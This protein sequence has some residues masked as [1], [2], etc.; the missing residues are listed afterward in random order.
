M[1]LAP[2]ARPQC[3]GWFVCALASRSA[4]DTLTGSAGFGS[5]EVRNQVAGHLDSRTYR[6]NYQD[7]CIALD[8]ASLVRGQETEDALIR[9]LNDVG[10][11]ADPGANVALSPEALEYIASLPDVAALQAERNRLAQALQEKYGSISRA[12][13]CE[14]LLGAYVQ[15]KTAHRTRKEFHKT[16]MRSQ[17]RQDFFVHKNAALIEAQ[18]LGG[19]AKSVNRPESKESALSIPERA[20]L[21]SLIGVGDMRE[22]SM[23]AQRAAAVEA[24]ADLCSRAELKRRPARLYQAP[25]D[26]STP[27][28]PP[29][30]ADE[31]FPMQCHHLQC[32]FC[33]GDTVL[34]LRDRTQIFSQQHTLW[35]HVA[36]H[37]D[38][39]EAGSQI[40]C[41]HPQ[42]KATGMSLNDLQHLKNHAQK[43]H[44]IRLQRC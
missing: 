27:E 15:A 21:S 28:P 18:L 26:N 12:P 29:L 13:A 10:T 17:M 34:N 8:V 22:P 1:V 35:R 11:N 6:N 42:C 4:N 36:V 24:M 39:V 5:E 19:D 16:R 30:R 40:L 37:L 32:L 44:G 14:E 38:S 2:P 25:S 43:A 23:R 33:L 9:R 7:Q 20:A 41:P 3:C 31:P